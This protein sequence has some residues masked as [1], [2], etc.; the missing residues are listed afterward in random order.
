M[1]EPEAPPINPTAVFTCV[2]RH[3]RKEIDHQLHTMTKATTAL[4]ASVF[5]VLWWLLWWIS[6]CSFENRCNLITRRDLGGTPARSG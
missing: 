4:L 5:F 2:G 1:M 6:S 3:T